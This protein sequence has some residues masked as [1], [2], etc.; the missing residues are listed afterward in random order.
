VYTGARQITVYY[1]EPIEVP[2]TRD[3]AADLT[4]ATAAAAAV[5]ERYVRRWP[6]QWFNFF[7]FW[8][9]GSSYN[10]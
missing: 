5:Y 3:R 9:D 4:R 10:G 1:E 6:E 7:D 2:H 8:A